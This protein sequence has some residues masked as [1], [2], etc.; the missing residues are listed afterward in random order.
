MPNDVIERL[1]TLPLGTPVVISLSRRRDRD[2]GSRRQNPGSANGS[3][4]RRRGVDRELLDAEL[5]REPFVAG[6][7]ELVGELGAAGRDDA[8]GHEH[9]HAIGAQLARA[10]ARSA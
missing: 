2:T 6:L 9:V 3:C 1:S 7:L 8:P 4:S 5:G 10:A